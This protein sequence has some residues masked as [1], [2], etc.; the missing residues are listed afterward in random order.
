MEIHGYP[1]V[2]IYIHASDASSMMC[3]GVFLDKQLFGV[4]RMSHVNV[5]VDSLLLMFALNSNSTL[6]DS[7]DVRCVT[8]V[9][10][11]PRVG[12]RI[13]QVVTHP[14]SLQ[15]ILHRSHILLAE[16]TI[17]KGSGQKTSSLESSARRLHSM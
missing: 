11:W 12:L 14:S 7:R 10:L 5:D 15:G 4:L 3:L 6:I 17:S 13:H 1:W 9:L 16:L 8:Q 2:S